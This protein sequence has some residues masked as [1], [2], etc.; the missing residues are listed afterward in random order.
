MGSFAELRGFVLAYRAC[1]ELR[2]HADPATPEGY[3]L[4]AGCSCG[5]RL[6]LPLTLRGAGLHPGVVDE[7]LFVELDELLRLLR[8]FVLGEDRLHRTHRLARSA[9]D[10]LVGV[11]EEL[12]RAL[13]DTVDWTDLDAG[14]VLD[15]DTRLSNDIRHGHSPSL[16]PRFLVHADAR[17]V[18]RSRLRLPLLGRLIPRAPTDAKLNELASAAPSRVEAR[19]IPPESCLSGDPPRR[20]GRRGACTASRASRAAPRAGGPGARHRAARSGSV[21]VRPVLGE[22]QMPASAAPQQA[23]FEPP[24]SRPTPL[25]HP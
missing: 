1:S 24:G 19:S 17:Q 22:A 9:V 12:I 18:P 14:L 6:K 5:A 3:R 13:V 7:E 16:V 8:G 25:S 20:T 15:V 23:I 2:G 10:T 21:E 4:W 11:Y